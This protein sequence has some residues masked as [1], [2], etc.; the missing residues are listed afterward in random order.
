MA[1]ATT[2]SLSGLKLLDV[3]GSSWIVV[4]GLGVMVV[5]LVVHGLRQFVLHR[6]A[7]AA[8]ADSAPALDPVGLRAP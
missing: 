6:R 5:A 8:Q 1:L 3:P 4:V 7:V 2:L